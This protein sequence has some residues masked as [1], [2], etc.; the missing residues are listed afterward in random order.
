MLGHAPLLDS[1]RR[2]RSPEHTRARQRDNSHIVEVGEET[3][4]YGSEP[5]QRLFGVL[6]SCAQALVHP[7]GLALSL[8]QQRHYCRRQLPVPWNPGL[9]ITRM[10]TDT[11]TCI[12]IRAHMYVC[13]C[14]WKKCASVD[15][16]T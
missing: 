15:T 7:R 8:K 14:A 9:Y 11:R 2:L 13:W 4:V 5:A 6:R 3:S 16:Y 12:C 1:C 10:Y